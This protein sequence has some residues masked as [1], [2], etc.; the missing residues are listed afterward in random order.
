VAVLNCQQQCSGTNF[1]GTK[2]ASVRGQLLEKH[3]RQTPMVI[4][5]VLRFVTMIVSTKEISKK[6]NPLPTH[7]LVY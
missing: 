7:T 2:F 4:R 6:K 3:E 1:E 5:A